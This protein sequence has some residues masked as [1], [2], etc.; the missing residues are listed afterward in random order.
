MLAAEDESAGSRRGSPRH[1]ASRRKAWSVLLLV[2]VG[3]AT[4]TIILPPDR[5]RLLGIPLFYVLHFAV[6]L[7][8]TAVTAL[9]Q[10]LTKDPD[11]RERRAAER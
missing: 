7:L 8:S 11:G 2:P 10:R 9:I 6:C 5:P 1:K 3:A 4:V